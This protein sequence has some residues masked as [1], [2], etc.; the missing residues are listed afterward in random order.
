[1]A[2]LNPEIVSCGKELVKK[3]VWFEAHDI[4]WTSPY[5][6]SIKLTVLDSRQA[7]VVGKYYTKNTFSIMTP[8]SNGKF[9]VRP[10]KYRYGARKYEFDPSKWPSYLD[11]IASL[12]AAIETFLFFK[13]EPELTSSQPGTPLFSAVK[14]RRRRWQIV[15]EE[16]QLWFGRFAFVS[17]NNIVPQATAATVLY[18]TLRREVTALIL[19]Y[20]KTNLTVI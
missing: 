10:E 9:R 14:H 6:I 7:T 5:S 17:F 1:M 2:E 16:L 13:T 4:G 11:Q 20:A 8:L 3:K 12:E 15:K 18:E 19:G